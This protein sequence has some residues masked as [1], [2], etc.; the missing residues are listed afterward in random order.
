MDCGGSDVVALL[1]F[2]VKLWET[3]IA[4]CGTILSANGMMTEKPT[5][6]IP[7]TKKGGGFH[8]LN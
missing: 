8:K 2:I 3:Q 1:L 6:D 4:D 5:R 7:F